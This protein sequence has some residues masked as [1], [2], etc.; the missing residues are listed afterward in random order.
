[1]VGV[2]VVGQGVGLGPS[3]TNTDDEL[4][5]VGVV[6][7]GQGVGL[8][9]S[10][11]KSSPTFRDVQVT[12]AVCLTVL[13]DELTDISGTASSTANTHEVNR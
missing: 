2:V 10:A 12:T 8:G 5:L 7:V 13:G 6:V 11:S 3:A 9:P 4:S 1:M